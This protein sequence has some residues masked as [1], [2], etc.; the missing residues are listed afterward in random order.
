MWL[1]PT[2]RKFDEIQVKSDGHVNC[3]GQ[4]NLSLA[5]QLTVISQHLLVLANYEYRLGGKLE[6]IKYEEHEKVLIGVGKVLYQNQKSFSPRGPHGGYH[7]YWVQY[8]GYS[9]M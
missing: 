4:T 1:C 8:V 3:Q 5:S 7:K 6:M 9:P 2:E